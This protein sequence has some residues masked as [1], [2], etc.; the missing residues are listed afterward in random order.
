MARLCAAHPPVW[1]ADIRLKV[2]EENSSGEI[3]KPHN[4][5]TAKQGRENKEIEQ[6][7]HAV[8]RLKE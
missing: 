8:N 5:D 2:L 6:E 1:H 7:T 4:T 3:R